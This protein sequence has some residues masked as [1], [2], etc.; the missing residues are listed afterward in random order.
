MELTVPILTN[1]LVYWIFQGF[2][3]GMPEIA[4]RTSPQLEQR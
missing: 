2:F 3:K 4:S 1:K